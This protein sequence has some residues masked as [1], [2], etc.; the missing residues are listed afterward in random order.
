MLVSNIV[1]EVS[2]ELEQKQITVVNSLKPKIQFSG[3]TTLYSTPSSAISWTTPSLM[4]APTYTSTSV[5]S[6]K[7]RITTISVLPIPASAFLPTS[8]PFVRTLLPCRQRTLAQVGRHR[9]GA[10]HSEECS[11]YSRRH[12]LCQKQPRW[13][14][15]VCIHT[16]KREITARFTTPNKM[17][18]IPLEKVLVASVACI[19]IFSPYR[20]DG[21]LKSP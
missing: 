12:H 7:T 21:L 4:P 5:V 11:P 3:A 8:E 14:T 20:H 19:G 17:L 1:N 16:G 18:C 9:L 10:R 15:G 13:R 2:L 6:A